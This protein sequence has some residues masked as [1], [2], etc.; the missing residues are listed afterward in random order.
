MVVTRRAVGAIIGWREHPG[1]VL[2]V[3]KVKT[4]DIARADINPEW[5]IPKGGLKDDERDDKGLWRELTEEVG[6]TEFTLV[7]KL[8]FGMNFKFP[9]GA[10]WGRQET[11]LFYLEYSG[12]SI[13]FKPKTDEIE[14]ARWFP[15]S[16]AK[17]IV[18]YATTVKAIEKVERLRL[19][20]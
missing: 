18:R 14:E 11:S 6:S 2:L 9:K 7:R 1:N 5:D 3:K 16:E 20:K 19:L 8:P 13:K 15:L 12:P 10:K 4:E 17:R